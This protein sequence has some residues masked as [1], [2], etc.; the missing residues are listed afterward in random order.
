MSAMRMSQHL[1]NHQISEW[2]NG[3][4]A[5]GDLLPYGVHCVTNRA[6]AVS[7]GKQGAGQVAGDG[8]QAVDDLTHLVLD[9]LEF[10]PD[11]DTA[12]GVGLSVGVSADVLA[13]AGVIVLV[14]VD[15]IQVARLAVAVFAPVGS[16]KDGLK[17]FR[18]AGLGLQRL[19]AVNSCVILCNSR[20]FMPGSSHQ[21]TNCA[22][23]P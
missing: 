11:F 18:A 4:R 20:R 19:T 3:D 16:S 2:R 5:Q 23:L 21:P 12:Q 13:L 6:E 9:G 8:V 1:A 17:S 22:A 10:I 7:G 15:E 14:E